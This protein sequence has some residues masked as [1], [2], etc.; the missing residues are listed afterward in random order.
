MKILHRHLMLTTALVLGLA[1]ATP[2]AMTQ[3]RA[4]EPSATTNPGFKPSTGQINPGSDQKNPTS[5]EPRKIPSQQEARAALLQRGAKDPNLPSVGEGGPLPLPATDSMRTETRQ[6]QTTAGGPE[7]TNAGTDVARN[8][9]QGSTN[10]LNNGVKPP[11]NPNQSAATTGANNNE[12]G[13]PIGSPKQNEPGQ[14]QVE[15]PQQSAAQDATAQNPAT[16]NTPAQTQEMRDQAARA[17]LHEAA[18]AVKAN[19]PIGATSQTMPSK[20]SPRNDVL[21]RV[22]IMAWPLPLNDADRQKLFQAVM[23]DKGQPAADGDTLKVANELT[24]AQALTGTTPLPESAQSST[25]LKGLSYI[26]TKD[27]VFLV[28]PVTRIVVDEISS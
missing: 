19:G 23:A 6:G 27:K 3:V 10:N 28:N 18:Q 24:P 7:T 26:K 21:D 15:R 22:P 1:A 12:V 2:L 4:A 11:T 5:S 13:K 17:A 9:S 14:G 8:G 16:Q 25:L 20:L